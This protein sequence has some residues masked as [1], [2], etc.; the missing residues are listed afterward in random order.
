MNCGRIFD[1]FRVIYESE[2]HENSTLVKALDIVVD[3]YFFFEGVFHRSLYTVANYYDSEDLW[4]R[5][6]LTIVDAFMACIGAL[7]FLSDQVN[8]RV[9]APLFTALVGNAAGAESMFYVSRVVVYGIACIPIVLSRRIVVGIG[10]TIL[11][12]VLAPV[13]VLVFIATKLMQ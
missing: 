9:A 1:F 8:E 3:V 5:I 7:N 10:A 4:I 12:I 6:Y 13:F 2:E 11:M